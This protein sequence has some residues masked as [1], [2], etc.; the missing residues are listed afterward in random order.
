MKVR[1]IL[2]T[3]VLLHLPCAY[4]ADFPGLEELMDKYQQQ[5]AGLYKL[6]PEEL[7]ALNHWLRWYITREKAVMKNK[8][9]GIESTGSKEQ[10]WFKSPDKKETDQKKPEKIVSQI[11]GEFSGWS[12]KTKFK[13]KNGQIWQQRI[14][15]K[16]YYKATEPHVEIKQNIFGLYRLYL[17]GT[18]YSVGVRRIK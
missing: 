6:T 2:I 16:L 18:P 15:R 3:F 4:A 13:L 17:T 11:E 14:K 1:I 12:G 5:Q 7:A 10:D 9:T 8:I